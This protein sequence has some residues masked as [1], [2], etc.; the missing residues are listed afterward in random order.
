MRLLVLI[1]ETF[2]GFNQT[3]AQAHGE[4]S[5]QQAEQAAVRRDDVVGALVAELPVAK[6]L[7]GTAHCYGLG[8]WGGAGPRGLLGG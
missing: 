8:A 6:A 1:F 4:R 3:V 2:G 5:G 7:G